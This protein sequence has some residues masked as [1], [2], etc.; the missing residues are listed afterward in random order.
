MSDS[1]LRVHHKEPASRS[2]G[3]G[4]RAVIWVQGC[5]LACPGC[6]NP[7]TH[8]TASGALES[9]GSLYQWLRQRFQA[10]DGVTISGGEPFQQPQALGDL[11]A[12][13]RSN[14]N[15]SILVFTGYTQNEIL[16]SPHCSALLPF[17]DVLIAGRYHSTQRLASGLRGSANKTIHFLTRRYAPADLASVPEAEVWIDPQGEIHLSGI[18]PLHW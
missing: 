11:L 1:F 5:S 13:V 3:P 14:T 6:F 9:V 16:R 18:D 17:I 8:S 15:L 7:E 4:L 12:L 2:N 10:L